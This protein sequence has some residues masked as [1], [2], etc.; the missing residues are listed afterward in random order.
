MSDAD[1]TLNAKALEGNT[2]HA[3]SNTGDGQEKTL[4]A[5]SEQTGKNLHPKTDATLH[6]TVESTLLE[7][8][9]ELNKML[10]QH[11]T[12]YTL[13]GVT[14]QV[15]K[16]LSDAT[17]EAQV[18]LLENNGKLFAL[19]LYFAD[20]HPPLG[21]MRIVK[22]SAASG[23]LVGLLEHGTWTD[24]RTNE[25]RDYE[26]MVYYEGE[27]LSKVNINRDE[28]KLAVIALRA[29]T[30]LDYLHKQQVI[31]RDIKPGNFFFPKDDQALETFVL[32]DF[33]I[34]VECDINGKATVD[35]QLRTKTYAAPEFYHSIDKHI[36]IYTKSDF[37]SLG[38]MLLTL[39]DGEGVF[40]I[41]EWDLS[42][43]KIMGKLPYPEDM[44]ERMLQL[45]K[46]LTVVDPNSR[47]GF[48][49]VVRWAK[50]E[51]I[52]N[53]QTGTDDLRKFK[54]LFNATKNQ[55]A[56]SP[57]ELVQFM[58]EDQELSIKYL[59]SGKITKW[60][61]ENLR[62]ELAMNIENIVETQFRTDK[63][64]G[65]TA[66]C[67][68]LDPELP[69]HDVSGNTLTNS[70]AI[71][72]SLKG[73]F[74]HYMSALANPNDSLFLFF[75]LHG[76]VHL[77]NKFAPLF[78]DKKD[79]HDALLQL[80]YV[81]DPKLPYLLT[82]SDDVVFECYTPD[83]IIRVKYEHT[84]SDAS[85][86]SLT[87]ESLLVWLG[88]KDMAL[89]GKIR[90][91]EQGSTNA[92]AVLYALDIRASYNLQLD[93]KADNYFFTHREVAE[94]M[95]SMMDT[96]THSEK[97][98]DDHVYAGSQ[99]AMMCDMDNTRLYHY[100]KSKGI[101]DDKIKW[102]EYCADVKSKDNVNKAGPYN[103]IIGV[104]KALK[105]LDHNPYYYFPKCK[106][107]AYNLDDL[108]KIPAK[109]LKEE[110][111]NGYL[112][113]WLTIFY[114]ENPHLDLSVKFAY[115]GEAGKYIEH[116]GR[117]D[118]KHADVKNYRIAADVVEKNHDAVKKSYRTH[119]LLKV[120]LGSVT[121]LTVGTTI[122]YL[123]TLK[124]PPNLITPKWSLIAAL[125]IGVYIGYKCLMNHF[126]SLFLSVVYGLGG[127]IGAF[128]VILLAATLLNY[129]VAA[130]L[131]AALVT[132]VVVCY[133]KYPMK[134]RENAGLINLGV[135]ER[136]LEPLHFTYIAK[137]GE[138]FKSSIGNRSQKYA[139][140]LRE[141]NKKLYRWLL[142]LCIFTLILGGVTIS[143]HADL[144]AEAIHLAEEKSKYETILGVWRGRYDNREATITMLQSSP[145]RVE[146]KI[147]VQHKYT[148]RNALAGVFNYDEKTIL[149]KSDLENSVLSGEYS[150]SFNE[151][152]TM[153]EMVHK[154]PKTKKQIKFKLER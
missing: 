5:L 34:A 132:V 43:M 65:F 120:V 131:L 15:A 67:Y 58:L 97:D 129:V 114:Q 106:K 100:L 119:L 138:Y 48:T 134:A 57:E 90:A 148:T 116:L 66:A 82:N 13:N 88:N 93:E 56:Y 41:S 37:Y 99:L 108:K 14:Y 60:L 18:F 59:Y 32:G 33:G 135:E 80:I 68:L 71:A 11:A 12:E 102:I 44:S 94:Y 123:L 151:E 62:P 141:G 49:E 63:E 133:V 98:S 76:F 110:V 16:V 104:Y 24:P 35:T 27:S 81:L 54:I 142:P 146:A 96:F 115:E 85:W 23:M 45:V 21:V 53:L 31:H 109:E 112:D 122:F 38:I 61:T 127:A 20:I 149:L 1:K 55:I 130:L 64:A 89:A 125:V 47:A 113:Y 36:E 83:D 3:G 154:N 19:K 145:H 73:H 40:R 78:K 128:F 77:T 7:K 79:R 9:G 137:A 2:L 144:E 22:K 42:R 28:K 6:G 103:W 105:G 74:N 4:H 25:R 30:L 29:A 136:Y 124:I 150:G 86:D 10:Q 8:Q 51:T 139:S 92:W 69:Y 101:Y 118:S 107:Y 75:N 153:L 17:G 46:A 147:E 152:M 143:F 52:F 87:S 84:L 26:L 117:L 50:G 121:L 95:N 70:E 91:H 72:A 140:Y 111:T 39:W 126:D